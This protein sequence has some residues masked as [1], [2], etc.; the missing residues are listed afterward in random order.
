MKIVWRSLGFRDRL[1][2]EEKI[3]QFS[4]CLFVQK[5]FP[6]LWLF[7]YIGVKSSASKSWG[8]I[9]FIRVNSWQFKKGSGWLLLGPCRNARVLGSFMFSTSA[10]FS[11]HCDL[12]GDCDRWGKNKGNWNTRGEETWPERFWCRSHISPFVG[13][14]WTLC[15]IDLIG[16][17]KSHPSMAVWAVNLA[18]N[19][20]AFLQ[21]PTLQ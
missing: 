11:C 5:A 1:N 4:V 13:W 2:L 15:V 8:P 17:T 20:D 16:A 3:I 14:T 21:I 18:G 19:P 10:A 7:F 12:R 9:T 6:K